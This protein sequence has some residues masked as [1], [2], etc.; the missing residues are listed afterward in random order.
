MTNYDLCVTKIWRV[1]ILLI[2]IDLSFDLHAA[3]LFWT[4]QLRFMSKITSVTKWF[5]FWQFLRDLHVDD[6][7]ASCNSS[8]EALK[9]YSVCKQNL[10]KGGFQLRKWESNNINLQKNI[11]EKETDNS[12]SSSNP[13]TDDTTYAQ[14]QLGLNDPQFWKVLGM[15]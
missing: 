10:L 4:P 12:N 3:H 14:Y 7:T 6:A 1:P 15:N 2:F 13:S 5:E 11:S 8:S 9:F